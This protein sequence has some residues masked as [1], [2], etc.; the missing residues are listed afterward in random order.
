MGDMIR[1]GAATDVGVVRAGNEDSHLVADGVY[2]VADGMGGHAA[3]EVASEVAVA[4]AKGLVG[5]TVKPED[6]RAAVLEANAAVLAAARRDPVHRGMGTTL[7]GLCLADFRGTPHWVVFNVGDSRVY[8]H[9]D[10]TLTQ[11]TTDHTELAEL[12]QAGDISPE[13]AVGHPLG[14]V[15]T[16]AI[17]MTPAPEPDLD[18]FP[19]APPERFLICSDGLTLEVPETAIA[20]VLADTDDP[21][22]AA[23]RL[24]TMAVD[25]GGR[26]NVTAV[27]VDLRR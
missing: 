5:R 12:V 1:A 11:L 21:G 20:G 3:G 13:E 2:V 10:G 22:A 18:V 8:R 7:T 4:V 16:R 19:V 26:D 6:V 9:V 27:V 14:N 23:E 15:L 25:A 24:V 17:G